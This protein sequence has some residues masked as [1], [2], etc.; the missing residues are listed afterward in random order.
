MLVRASGHEVVT[1]DGGATAIDLIRKDPPDVILLDLSMPDVD[2]FAVLKVLQ[3]RECLGEP[4]ITVV[5]LSAL[6]DEK[7]RA[8]ALELGAS[9]YLVK[10]STTLL[11]ILKDVTDRCSPST[12]SPSQGPQAKDPGHRWARSRRAGA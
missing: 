11:D 3:E 10:G 9:E 7:S 6:D 1:A 4:P 5:V 8:R 12:S 2:G